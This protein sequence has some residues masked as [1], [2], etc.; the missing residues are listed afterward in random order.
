[1]FHYFETLIDP[2]RAHDETM[3]PATLAGF[4]WRYLRQVWP[5]IAALMAIGLVV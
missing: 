5:A 2:F 3:P 1:M 4:Y